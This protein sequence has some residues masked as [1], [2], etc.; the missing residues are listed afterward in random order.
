MSKFDQPLPPSLGRFLLFLNAVVGILSVSQLA[1]GNPTFSAWLAIGAGVLNQ[2]IQIF[3]G[4]GP[5]NKAY[6][7]ATDSTLSDRRELRKRQNALAGG[8]NAKGG[9]K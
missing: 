1:D 3:V 6:E 8:K 2:A 7:K 5:Q 4:V 9:P